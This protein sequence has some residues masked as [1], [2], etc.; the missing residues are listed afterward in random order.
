MVQGLALYFGLTIPKF[1]TCS[2]V[3]RLQALREVPLEHHMLLAVCDLW[4]T[5][6]RL[7]TKDV[8]NSVVLAD[9]AFNR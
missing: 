3:R 6:I 2:T 5:L 4:F 9:F 1:Y 7:S 8:I